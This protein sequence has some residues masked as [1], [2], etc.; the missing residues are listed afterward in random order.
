MRGWG[1]VGLPPARLV[2]ATSR[3]RAARR[4]VGQLLKGYAMPKRLAR[5]LR[6]KMWALARKIRIWVRKLLHSLFLG[7]AKFARAACGDS[8]GEDAPN[9]AMPRSIR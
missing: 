6:S 1:W 2:I 5:T 4:E 7:I 9:F 3:W 8:A